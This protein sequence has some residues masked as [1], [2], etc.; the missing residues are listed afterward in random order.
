MRKQMKNLTV[1]RIIFKQI[2]KSP[3]TVRLIVK[4]TF[5]YLI[6]PSS[7]RLIAKSLSAYGQIEE[8][9]CLDKIRRILFSKY[10]KFKCL[11]FYFEQVQ[12]K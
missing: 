5:I 3:L 11:I 1:S 4:C 8:N 9:S 2:V 6:G 7:F 12:I 10:K